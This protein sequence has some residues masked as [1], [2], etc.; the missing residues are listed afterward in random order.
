MS[1]SWY[2][3]EQATKQ[4]LEWVLRSLEMSSKNSR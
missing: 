2:E 4:I 1:H 3:H